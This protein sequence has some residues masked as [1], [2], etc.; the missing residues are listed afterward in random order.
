MIVVNAV[1][2]TVGTTVV[3]AMITKTINVASLVVIATTS[4]TSLEMTDA[5]E[6]TAVV[7][8]TVAGPIATIGMVNIA[9]S[10]LLTR[11]PRILLPRRNL[12]VPLATV[13][14][15]RTRHSPGAR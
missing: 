5:T 1:V 15:T 7:A 8:K 13:G 3:A 2:M 4:A 14:E 12:R 6:T 9:P 11:T 10:T